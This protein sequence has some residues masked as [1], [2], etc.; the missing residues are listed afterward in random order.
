MASVLRA[1]RRRGRKA[2]PEGSSSGP[3]AKRTL[4]GRPTTLVGMLLAAAG[5]SSDTTTP[6]VD[7]GDLVLVIATVGADPDP[8]GYTATLDGNVSLPVAASGSVTFSQVLAGEHELSLSG[9]A[10]QCMSARESLSVVVEAGQ[11]TTLEESVFCETEPPVLVGAG[12]IATCDL[13]SDDATAV[14][15]DSIPGTVFTAG[16]NVYPNGTEAEF[17]DCYE[18]TWG[19]HRLRTR[20][21]AGNHDYNTAGATG[22]YDYFGPSAGEAD[23]GYYSFDLGTWHIEVLNSNLEDVDGAAQL[24]WL[25]DDLAM[26][27]AACTAAYWHHPRFSSGFHGNDESVDPLWDALYAAGVEIAVTGHDHHYER[28]APQDGDGDPDPAAGIREFVVGTGGIDLFPAPFV[29]ANSE[30]RRSTVHGVL[31]LSLAAGFY[32]WE[33]IAAPG[34]EIV[35]SGV[36][37][38]H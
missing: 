31:K 1:V 3:E 38:C 23:K 22:Y 18:P 16:D 25:E 29:K 14:L 36:S 30:V 24:A 19:R 27:P 8:D 4:A 15:L 21:A 13:D 34:G 10:P 17:A 35:D 32:R 28:F 33:F 2:G 7:S 11:V 12:D 20:P 37:A 5:C 9:L 26:N 6:P